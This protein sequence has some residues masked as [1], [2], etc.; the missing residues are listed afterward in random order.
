GPHDQ[1]AARVDGGSRHGTAR[2]DLDRYGL[3]GQHA[4]VDGG[5]TFLDG[6]VG[7]DLLPRADHEQISDRDLLDRDEHLT[8]CT[9]DGDLLGAQFHEGAQSRPRATLGT[10]LEVLAEEDEGGDPRRD[11]QVDVGGPVG[12]GDREL[13]GV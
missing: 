6:A 8:S 11:L 12:A 4:H 2:L 1:A 13:E 9:Q 7:G 5:G 3:A 10:C